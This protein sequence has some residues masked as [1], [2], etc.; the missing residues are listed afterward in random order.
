MTAFD[1]IDYGRDRL[2]ET[3]VDPDPLIQ[4][5]RWFA[6]AREAGVPE[7][8]AMTLATAGPDGPNARIVLLKGL[9]GGGFVFY[10]HYAS[11]KGRELAADPRAALVFF[12]QPVERQVRILGR[13][14]P[15]TA[16]ESD[17]YFGS[18]PEGSRVGAWASTQSAVLPNRAALDDALAKA[19]ARFAGKP[20]PRPEHWG[21]YRL[22]PDVVEF[23]QGRPNRL[24]D[25]VR[26]SRDGAGWR[27]ERLSP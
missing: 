19:T 4:F 17:E 2:D 16:A 25:R 8:N 22:I 24:H 23:W 7:P 12:W 5:D 21:G 13:V 26:Y 3:A 14:V 18:R 20:V 1:R 10:T 9:D 11:P 15:V 6:A 27:R